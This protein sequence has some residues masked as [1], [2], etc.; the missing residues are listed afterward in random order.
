M[1]TQNK[2]VQLVVVSMLGSSVLAS[3]AALA[4]DLPCVIRA[5][6]WKKSEDAATLHDVNY[7]TVALHS[8]GIAAYATGSFEVLECSAAPWGIGTA[9]C[10]YSNPAGA[11][12]SN[13]V[14]R[15]VGGY[16]QP[17]DVRNPLSLQI[18]T[19]PT[20]SLGFVRI[21]QPNA[22]Y[23]IRSP[24]CVNDLL[25]GNDQYGNHWT[26]SFQLSSRGVVR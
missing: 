2:L 18:L 16:D 8:S 25:T 4:A 26:I 11:L 21:R 17:F 7:A 1:F 19:I 20:D 5:I 14:G 12:L 22:T 9:E 24:Q 13:R 15:T 23:A 3:T 6:N 10:L